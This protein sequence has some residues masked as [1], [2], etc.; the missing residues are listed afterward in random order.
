MNLLE[1]TDITGSNLTHETTS[2]SS[3]SETPSFNHLSLQNF[4]FKKLNYFLAAEMS[5]PVSAINS[6]VHDLQ[7]ALN[8]N[9]VSLDLL[10][11]KL[12]RISHLNFK[13]NRLLKPLQILSENDGQRAPCQP[14]FLKQ[15]VNDALELCQG[16]LLQ[17]QV[18]I[19]QSVDPKLI[20]KARSSEIIQIIL[21]L[22]QNSIQA[23]FKEP[24][25]WIQMTATKED[26]NACLTIYD[27]GPGLSEEAIEHSKNSALHGIPISQFLAK[28]NNGSLEIERSAEHTKFVLRLPR[29]KF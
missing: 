12:N 5:N 25:P 8:K 17:H 15:I 28:N 1:S 24:K 2:L 4:F 29:A 22:I 11:D 20:V 13:I 6:H 9:H 18:Q 19:F 10:Q 3:G 14:V 21:H 7:M 23:T 26:N 16:R 27:C